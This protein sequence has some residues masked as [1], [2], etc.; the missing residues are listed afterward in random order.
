MHCGAWLP[1]PTCQVHQ[2]LEAGGQ[3]VLCALGVPEVEGL[4]GRHRWELPADHGE[5]RGRESVRAGAST[6]PSPSIVGSS[7]E[8]GTLP[9]LCVH[10][11]VVV[12]DKSLEVDQASHLWWEALQLVVAQVEV[13]QV[14]QVDEEL[15]GD[16]LDA[17]GIQG[18][19]GLPGT[20]TSPGSPSKRGTEQDPER[21]GVTDGGGH[22]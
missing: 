17:A 21:R 12:E 9:E 19:S 7:L 3:I 18:S 4:Q 13:E 5:P 20:C 16:G 15:V 6:R 11:G 14:R 2:A 8:S 1:S 10:E 22:G